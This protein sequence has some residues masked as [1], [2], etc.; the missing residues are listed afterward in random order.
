MTQE[1]LCLWF[2]LEIWAEKNCFHFI[3]YFHSLLTFIQGSTL[4]SLYSLSVLAPSQMKYF[5]STS[6]QSHHVKQTHTQ[7]TIDTH[8]SKS[9]PMTK[10]TCVATANRVKQP[11]SPFQSICSI[12]DDVSTRQE[13]N[14]RRV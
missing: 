7:V 9:L 13:P 6:Q 1:P 8:F 14:D 5:F 12:V 11:F 4:P 10:V 2:L 3:Y